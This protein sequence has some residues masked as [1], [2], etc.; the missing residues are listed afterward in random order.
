MRFSTLVLLLL[1]V[2]TM[3]L[4]QQRVLVTSGGDA[5]LLKKGESALEVA[6]VNGLIK[7]DEVSAATCG[8][9]TS[10]GFDKDHYPCNLPF[11]GYHHDVW[12]QWFVAPS[13]GTIETL[14]VYTNDQNEMAGGQGKIAMFKSNIYPGHGPGYAPYN[15]PRH[16]WGYYKNS[17][18]ADEAYGITP[19]KSRATDP[20]WIPTNV[21]NDSITPT[22]APDDSV[23]FDPLGD[24]IWP[25]LA[26]G[27]FYPKT[28][29]INSVNTIVMQDLTISPSVAKGDPIFITIEE[30]GTHVTDNSNPATWCMS[31]AGIPTIPQ[32]WKFYTHVAAGN[33]GWHARAEASWMWWMVMNVTGDVPPDILALDRLGH[34]LSTGSRVV[35][36][37]IQDCNPGAGNN[38][39]SLGVASVTLTYRINGGS[40]VTIPMPNDGGDHYSAAIPGAGADSHVLYHITCTDIK[41]N[42]KQSAPTLYSV[43]GLRNPYYVTD[44][45]EVFNWTELSGN[46]GTMVDPS[47]YFNTRGTQGLPHDDGS[48]GPYTIPGGPVTFFGDT[49][50]IMWVGANGGL[51][52]THTLIDTQQISGSGGSFS[53]NWLFPSAV[54]PN[55]DMPKN[56]VAPLSNDFSVFGTGFDADEPY[57]HGAIW[58][59]RSGSKFIVEWDSVGVVSKLIADTL[60]SFEVIF[61]D[62]D[63][64]ITYEY[65]KVHGA[66]G[67]DTSS[68]MGVQADSL[69][70]WVLLNNENN[71]PELR[72]RDG[73]AIKLTPPGAVAAAVDGWNLVSVPTTPS[74]YAKSFVYPTATSNA[75]AFT[76]SYQVVDPLSNGPGYWIKVSGD[77]SLPYPGGPLSNVDITVATGWN[78]IG[79][80]GSSVATASITSAPPGIVTGATYYKFFGN[81]YVPVATIDPGL[82]YW[83]QTTGAGTLTLSASAAAP[84]VA[85]PAEILSQMNILRIRDNSGH[86]QTLYFGRSENLAVS[87]DKF[88]MPPAA[89]GGN[90]D[91]R[92]ASQR[93]VEVYPS[94]LK[95][96]ASSPILVTASYPI[97]ISWT[98]K[99]Q[100]GDGYNLVYRNGTKG[101]MIHTMQGNGSVQIKQPVEGLK[102]RVTSSGSPLPKEFA[103]GQNYPNPFNPTTDIQYALPADAYVSF[104]VYN[105]AGQEVATL[106]DGL[107]SAGYHAV[108]WNARNL[109]D[110]QL[111]SGVYFYRLIATGTN[112]SNASFDQVR[113]MVLLK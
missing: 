76:G 107:Q 89:P 56:F 47:K 92:F 110:A 113:K 34:T 58:Y 12:G 22:G 98:M 105:I 54:I 74:S 103:L 1:V 2:S 73:R 55:H 63:K 28:F 49:I 44:T 27:E 62:A 88:A 65:K 78:M 94:D 83:V 32:N 109:S 108:S 87:A 18:Q 81:S 40:D 37:S 5:I 11:V 71:A 25:T 38:P 41:G 13:S 84:E 57:A 35:T 33:R 36:A 26:L 79:S 48:A 104:K 50:S 102:L 20:L 97:T 80:I 69:T 86:E 59:K 42:V 8:S 112:G 43:I 45:T 7:S 17:N 100:N 99:G 70:K 93:M 72:P 77:Q 106:V 52:L 14:F 67:L 39:D 111:G 9:T 68:L 21:K 64:S 23:S 95:G 90:L 24:N 4:A 3:L 30:L 51:S 29:T 101:E 10:F 46:G 75:F 60:H 61:D 85:S 6:R 91:V 96:E 31:S 53:G 82:G 15:A 16:S 66:L 19:F